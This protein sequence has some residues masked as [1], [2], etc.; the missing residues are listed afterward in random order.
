MEIELNTL[1]GRTITFLNIDNIEKS[2]MKVEKN[3][4][5]LSITIIQSGG[6]EYEVLGTYE[7]IKRA[8]SDSNMREMSIISNI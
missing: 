6:K 1:D 3:K 8:I 4:K 2:K 7:D 5:Q